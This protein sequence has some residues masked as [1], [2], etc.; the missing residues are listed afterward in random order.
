MNKA[1]VREPDSVDERCP[2][3]GCAGLRVTE[4]TLS[5]FLSEE[6]I[7]RVSPAAYFC[8]SPTCEALYFNGFEQVIAANELDRTFYPKDPGSPICACFGLT[9]DEIEQDVAEGVVT[10][11]R[12]AVARAKSDEAM[13]ATQSPSGRSCVAEVQKYYMKCRAT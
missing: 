7:R 10:R 8:P 3:C 2:R 1:F 12:A 5:S 9:C 11:T 4:L 13:C 6:Q